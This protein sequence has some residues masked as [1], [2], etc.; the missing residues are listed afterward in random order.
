MLLLLALLRAIEP[1]RWS[2]ALPVAVITPLVVWYA[3]ER[4]LRIQVPDGVFSYLN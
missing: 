4:L 3:L 2:T 1:V